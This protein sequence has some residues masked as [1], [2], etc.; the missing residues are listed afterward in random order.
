MA[1]LEALMASVGQPFTSDPVQ[2]LIASDQV[3]ESL[4][5]ALADGKL[6]R[7]VLANRAG[8]YQLSHQLGRV[9][10]VIIHAQAGRGFEAFAG[11]L[12]G[13]VSPQATQAEVR[14]KLGIPPRSGIADQGPWDRF[15]IGASSACFCYDPQG[16]HILWTMIQPA[17]GAP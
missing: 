3:V 13:G 11:P 12:P 8:G 16:E 2:S 5:Q 1:T 9:D 7:T 15:E 4:E 6:L 10:M 17:S 14:C